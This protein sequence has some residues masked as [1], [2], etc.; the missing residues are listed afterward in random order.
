MYELGREW[1]A[2]FL[3]EDWRRPTADEAEAI[4]ARH[5]FT[6]DFWRLG[7]ESAEPGEPQ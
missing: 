2:A 5:G 3:D 4:F 6:G 7:E 1:F